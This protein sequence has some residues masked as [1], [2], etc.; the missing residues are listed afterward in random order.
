MTISD[1]A[2]TLRQCELF[3]HLGDRT[4]NLMAEML[5]EEHF[6]ANETVFERGDDADRLYVVASGRLYVHRNR[7]RI[8]E[9]GPGSVI[10][11]Y[12][13]FADGRRTATIIAV[14][15]TR[16]LALDYARFRRLLAEFP[17]IAITILTTTVRRLVEL[18]GRT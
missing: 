18:E 14:D 13:A 15:P 4:L 1:R 6:A 3:A 11:E 8:R 17:E 10:G 12:G 2:V 7:I 5:I 16:L 9:M